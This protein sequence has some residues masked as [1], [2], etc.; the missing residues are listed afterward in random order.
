MAR[1]IQTVYTEA[2]LQAGATS[3]SAEFQHELAELLRQIEE[4][5]EQRGVE[6]KPAR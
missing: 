4:E 1:R 3:R 2:E 5:R 6:P